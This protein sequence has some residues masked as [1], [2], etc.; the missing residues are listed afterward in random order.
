MAAGYLMWEVES[1]NWLLF[2]V[3]VLFLIMAGKPGLAVMGLL[4]ML[5]ALGI[6]V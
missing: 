3:G 5:A 1:I 2:I 4:V 6:I